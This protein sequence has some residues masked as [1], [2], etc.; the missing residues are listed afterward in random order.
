MSW[1][2][3]NFWNKK[4]FFFPLWRTINNKFHKTNSWRRSMQSRCILL[5]SNFRIKFQKCSFMWVCLC[6]DCR[7]CLCWVLPV[8]CDNSACLVV[9]CKS[10]DSW[11]DK[12]EAVLWIDIMLW[13]FKVLADV[14]CLLDEVVNLFWEC[15]C[16][17]VCTEDA[18][19][20]DACDGANHAN[21]TLISEECAD[22][23]WADTLLCVVADHLNALL[24]G[25]LE[26]V[27]CCT[28]VWACWCRDTFAWRVK[29]SHF[30]KAKQTVP[31]LSNFFALFVLS[32]LVCYG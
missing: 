4:K 10:V 13:A 32:P 24:W 26:P 18:V 16:K 3:L 23:W 21:A 27:W 9:T 15:W 8:W 25:N 6:N 22:L 5:T 30:G 19:D 17:A 29:T 7:G 11:F 1:L 31:I 28:A 12:D 2:W 14:C 20:L